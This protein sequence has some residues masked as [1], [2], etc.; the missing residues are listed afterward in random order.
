MKKKYLPEEEL[1]EKM[2]KSEI[3]WL[4]Y[5]TG[6]SK[7]WD[8]EFAVFL[9]ETALEATEESAQRFLEYRKV[10]MEKGLEEGNM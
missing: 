3:G 5:V 10:R 6:F 8:E 1:I 9:Q 4:E 7:E 2:Q